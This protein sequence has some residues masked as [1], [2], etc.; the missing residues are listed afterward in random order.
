MFRAANA[1]QNVVQEASA[2]LRML[3]DHITREGFEIRRITDLALV[4]SQ[5]PAFSL[6]W[7]IMHV[8]DETSPLWQVTGESLGE[9]HTSFVLSVGGTDETTGQQLMARAEF[10]STALRWNHR[11]RDVLELTSD[12]ILSVDYRR[13]DEIEPLADAAAAPADSA[14][15]SAMADDQRQ[16]ADGPPASA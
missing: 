6:T 7:T 14:L 9:S 3:R 2:K 10:P 12:D 13:F 16:A 5:H 15:E 11:F 8:I 4:R 1:R